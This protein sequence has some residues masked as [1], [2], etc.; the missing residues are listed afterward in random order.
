MNIITVERIE[1]KI[2]C[3]SNNSPQQKSFEY[4]RDEKISPMTVSFTCSIATNRKYKI[5]V[6]IKLSNK[7]N[8]KNPVISGSIKIND[9]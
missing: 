9:Q 2:D 7:P 1:I 3:G 6:K 4:A 5:V 8:N